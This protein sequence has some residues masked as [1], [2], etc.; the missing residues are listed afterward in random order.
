MRWKISAGLLLAL[1]ILVPAASAAAQTG[2][3][4]VIKASC[5]TIVYAD[6]REMVT[7]DLDTASDIDVRVLANQILT[8]ARAESL[9]S[10]R[11]WTAPRPI[12][13]RSSRRTCNRPGRPTCGSRWSRR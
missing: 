11:R 2:S 8:V 3:P 6:I 4:R 7:I 13:A 12:S 10:R 9:T 5:Q 1:A